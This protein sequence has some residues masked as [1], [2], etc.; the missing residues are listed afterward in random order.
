MKIAQIAP[1]FERVPAKKY[2]GTERVVHAL[3]EELVRMGHE[4]TLFASGDSITSAKLVS[5]QPHSLRESGVDIGNIYQPTGWLLLHLGLPYTLQDEF[6][7]IH[8]HHNRISLPT[9]NLSKTPVIVTV[10]DPLNVDQS[11]V[12]LMESMDT[13]N[14]VSISHAQQTP[15]PHLNWVGNVYN[16]T[17]SG[18]YPFS[19]KPGKYLLFVGRMS[20]RKGVHFAIEAAKKLN[21]P[22]IIAAK[23]DEA[24]KGNHEYYHKHVE[25]HLSDQIRWVGEVD[26]EERNQLMSNALCLLHP[27]NF[28]EPFG[29]TLPEAMACGCPVVAFN[30]GSIPEIIKDGKTGFVVENVDQMVEAVKKIH[31][32]SR[33][34]C[35][36][37]AFTHYNPRRMA[38]E[39]LTVYQQILNQKSATK[40]Q[41]A[42]ARNALLP[43]F[44]N[45]FMS[46]QQTPSSHQERVYFDKKMNEKELD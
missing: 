40:N 31:T 27:V 29:L 2:G 20:E 14:Y 34:Y 42:K 4:V 22:L 15:A 3:T 33:I 46:R 1:L 45:P 36:I 44:Q 8:D 6:D 32:I 13:I 24:D 16:G 41:S 37:Y 25:P 11:A 10:H 43:S 30:K 18:K 28:M 35:R 39:Y 12:A 19:E 21:M 9:A 5:V 38:E 17:L 26:E 23:L 7:I